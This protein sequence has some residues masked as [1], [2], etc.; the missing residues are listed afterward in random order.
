MIDERAQVFELEQQRCQA[1]L[2]G[3]LVALGQLLDETCI[4]VHGSGAIE[5]KPTLLNSRKSLKWLVLTR[6][7]LQLH[8]DGDLAVLTGR[9]VFQTQTAGS[10]DILAGQAFATQILVRRGGKWLFILHHATRL[11]E[12]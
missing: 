1:E 2:Q 12:G 10:S 6:H 11:K 8:V 7:D 3:D 5:D 9:L 4:H